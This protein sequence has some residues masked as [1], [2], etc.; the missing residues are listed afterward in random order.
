VCLTTCQTT[1]GAPLGDL[2]V[3]FCFS[4]IFRKSHKTQLW[5]EFFSDVKPELDPQGITT[6]KLCDTKNGTVVEEILIEI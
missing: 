5:T 3:L 1:S 4:F 6:V 2:T